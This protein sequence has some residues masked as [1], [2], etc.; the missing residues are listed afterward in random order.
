MVL[1]LEKLRLLVTSHGWHREQK[2]PACE[3][4]LCA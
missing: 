2:L 4:L 3:N 1:N